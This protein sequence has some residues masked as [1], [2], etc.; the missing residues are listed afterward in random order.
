MLRALQ[1]QTFERV[2]GEKPIKSDVRIICATNIDLEKAIDEGRF[3][4]DLYYRLHVFPLHLPP[5]RE[6]G[7]DILLL[8]QFFLSK[9]AENLGKET[10]TISEEALD[11][12][13]KN[14]W[15]GN[16]RE[17]QNTLERAAIVCRENMIDMHHLEFKNRKNRK[18][19]VAN[20]ESIKE[21]ESIAPLDEA[22]RLHI[23]SAL[24]KSSGHIYGAKWCCKT[25][26]T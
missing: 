25:F 12:L 13:R 26:R 11:Y 17:L 7:D 23:I 9:I 6:R 10:M 19:R 15:S 3:R 24:E 20:I 18:V 8:T 5:L 21:A 4:E 22:I 1:E 2:G 16:V 14:R